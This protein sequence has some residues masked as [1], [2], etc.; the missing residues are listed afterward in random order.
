LKVVLLAVGQ[1]GAPLREAI[2][3]YEQRAA[4]YWTWQS[5]EVRAE[6][7]TRNTP[8]ERVLERE[9]DRL[10]ERV[11]PGVELI[12]MTRAGTLWDSEQLARHLEQ[13]AIE[14]H[15]GVAFVIGG[16]FGLGQ[17]VLRRAARQL[18][19]SRY[20]LPHELARLVLTEQL[21]RAGTLLRGEPY[22]KTR[23]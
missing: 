5:I 1:P 12:A 9:A 6:K 10:L 17:A 15:A 11:P 7:A 8:T 3:E 13:R 18:S 20:T 2:R 16:A 22:H 14:A 19:L 21:Y 4:H 23:P